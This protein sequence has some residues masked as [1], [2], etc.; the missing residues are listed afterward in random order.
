LNT[1]ISPISDTTIAPEFYRNDDDDL[2]TNLQKRL[3]VFLQ[4]HISG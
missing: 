1:Q 2:I 3:P 4:Q